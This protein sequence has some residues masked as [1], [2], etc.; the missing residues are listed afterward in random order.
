MIYAARDSDGNFTGAQ[1][2]ALSEAIRSHHAGFGETISPVVAL[3]NIGTD[4]RPEWEAVE[5]SVEDLR[6]IMVVSRL[7]ARAAL[8]QA[9]LLDQVD[10]MIANGGDD[11]MIDAWAS[12]VEFRRMSPMI[13]TMG[14]ALDLDDD[15]MDSLFIAAAAISV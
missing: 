11:L 4:D 8:R 7:Q 15:D 12:A 9:G 6:A 2:D 14:A 10:A 13:I 1:Y 5:A 3:N